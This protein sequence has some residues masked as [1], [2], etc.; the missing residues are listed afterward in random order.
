M[1]A[2]EAGEPYRFVLMDIHMPGSDGIEA[3]RL[4]RAAEAAQDIV[5]GAPRVPILAL[6]ADVLDADRDACRSAGMDG[7]LAKPFDRERLVAA[8]DAILDKAQRAAA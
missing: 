5:P 4:I 7:L 8:L 1:S 2:R 3:T 6:S